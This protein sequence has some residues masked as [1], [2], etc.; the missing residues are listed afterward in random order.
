M[1]VDHTGEQVHIKCRVERA[2]PLTDWEKS[3]RLARL[4]GLGPENISFLF[5]LLHDLLPT[6]EHVA[7]T[8]PTASP[9]C[10]APGCSCDMEDQAHALVSCQSN[11]GVG[12]RVIRCLQDFVP[13]IDVDAALRLEI[14]IEEEMELPLVWMMATVFQAIWRSELNLKPESTS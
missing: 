5:K 1:E 2:S 14:D 8:K 4:P 3:W 10:Q 11:H 7:R 13:N 9:A 12:Q 6:Q